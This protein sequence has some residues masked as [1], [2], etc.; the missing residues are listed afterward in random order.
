MNEKMIEGLGAAPNAKM[1]MPEKRRNSLQEVFDKID[2]IAGP[3]ATTA[4]KLVVAK[5]LQNEAIEK[6]NE[7]FMEGV[8]AKLKECYETMIKFYELEL[9]VENRMDELDRI[10]PGAR[11]KIAANDPHFLIDKEIKYKVSN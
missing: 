6:K 11:Q 9:E 8:S 3:T 5:K 1:T 2:L 7:P 4:E 10:L